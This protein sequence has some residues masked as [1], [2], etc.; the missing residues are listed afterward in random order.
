MLKNRHQIRKRFVKGQDIWATGKIKLCAQA[1][2]E[3]VG[4]LMD[5]NVVRQARKDK[6]SGQVPAGD[7]CIRTKIAKADGS[8]LLI[9]IGVAIIAGMRSES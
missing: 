5:D 2:Q 3:C 8:V 1:I 6:A 9:V 4:D 7:F